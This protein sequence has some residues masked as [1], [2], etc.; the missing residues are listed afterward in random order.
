MHNPH[1]LY[2][3]FGIWPNEE[4]KG[5]NQI[6]NQ[7]DEIAR[8]CYGMRYRSPSK[9]LCNH[10]NVESY[11][12]DQRAIRFH[13]SEF[14]DSVDDSYWFCHEL[15]TDVINRHAP[16]KNRVV[17]HK[18]LP[19]MNDELRRAMNVKKHDEGYV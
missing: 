12:Q 19:Y 1:V 15:L 6:T 11:R 17:T 2:M 3:A 5:Q 18:Q 4:K 7:N 9:A 16:T 8:P 14:F 10:C 13:V